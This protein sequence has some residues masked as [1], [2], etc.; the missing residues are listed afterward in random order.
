MLLCVS[1]LLWGARSQLHDK[2]T[3]IA[4]VINDLGIG[5]AQR[6]LTDIAS[7]LPPD[8]FKSIV[9]NLNISNDSHN[10]K[11][12]IDRNIKVFTSPFRCKI[13]VRRIIWLY[14]II[15][16]ERPQIIHSHLWISN[17]LTFLIGHIAGCRIILT[18][19]HNT[20]TFAARSYPYRAFARLYLKINRA[21]VAVSNAVYNEI[22]RCSRS[23]AKNCKIIYNGVDTDIF[24]PKKNKQSHDHSPLII[25]TLLRDDPRKGFNIFE[26]AADILIDPQKQ[27]F[28]AAFWND[29]GQ[30]SESIKPIYIDGTQR[31]VAAYMQYV[32]IF[33][34]PSLEEGLGLV[35]L[36]A[37]AS[38]TIV[39]A[40][41]VGGIPEIIQNSKNGFL[42]K[43]GDYHD[44]VKVLSYIQQA[45]I[46]FEMITSNARRLVEEQFSLNSM[47]SKYLTLYN[48]LIAGVYEKNKDTT[49]DNEVGS[50]R[51]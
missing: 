30:V 1:C 20:T 7:G 23:A 9:V 50:R 19:E 42:F 22:S 6:V 43:A 17:V 8:K 31:S 46:K 13:D 27:I 49:R 11:Y 28:V 25:G 21:S 4:F 47:T 5:G 29:K 36:E 10:I 51:G 12:L 24:K 40:S 35:L 26:K 2:M 16:M 33:V 38:K 41:K 14:K 32:D 37:M 44:L 3:K 39:V 34:L 18:T 15:K 45:P 48:E